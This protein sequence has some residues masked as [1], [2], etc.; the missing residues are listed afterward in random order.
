MQEFLEYVIKNLV[1]V[2]EDVVITPVE[3]GGITVYASNSSSA[4]V[5]AHE[6]NLIAPGEEMSSNSSNLTPLIAALILP[7]KKISSENVI[8]KMINITKMKIG[9]AQKR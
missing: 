4:V 3:R 2:P 5:N 6:K 7:M 8:W 9:I 1:A